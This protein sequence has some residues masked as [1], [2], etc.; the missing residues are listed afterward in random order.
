MCD[1]LKEEYD[2]KI[3]ATDWLRDKTNASVNE[4]SPIS[5]IICFLLPA[6]LLVVL[7]FLQPRV[8]YIAHHALP[9]LHQL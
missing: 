5:A 7:V 8:A 6:K 3:G 4:N 2:A 9:L 1:S